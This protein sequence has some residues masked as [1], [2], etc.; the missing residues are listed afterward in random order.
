MGKLTNGIDQ[1]F[2]FDKYRTLEFR[3]DARQSIEF[4][5]HQDRDSRQLLSN[6]IISI[7]N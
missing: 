7:N 1:W 2:I 5:A 3:F 6:N 4:A